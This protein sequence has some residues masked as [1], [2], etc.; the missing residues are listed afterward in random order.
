MHCAQNAENL[1]LKPVTCIVTSVLLRLKDGRT[2]LLPVQFSYALYYFLKMK[3]IRYTKIRENQISHLCF[4]WVISF[5]YLKTRNTLNRDCVKM[6]QKM[7]TDITFYLL[8]IKI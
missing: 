7:T 8:Q 2:G 5:L 3:Y 4:A 6:K 1:M